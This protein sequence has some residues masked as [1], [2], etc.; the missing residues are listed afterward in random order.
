MYLFLVGFVASGLAACAAYIYGA[1]N[2]YVLAALAFGAAGLFWALADHE[3]RHG[4]EPNALA[5]IASVVAVSSAI[6]IGIRLI[7]ALET[8]IAGLCLGLLWALW[9]KKKFGYWP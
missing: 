2:P 7:G 5:L 3:I 8:A 4:H 6:A 9:H 1:G